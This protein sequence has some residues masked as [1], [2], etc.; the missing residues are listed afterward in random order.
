MSLKKL[1]IQRDGWIS[2]VGKMMD[3]GAPPEV[4]PLGPGYGVLRTMLSRF[5]GQDMEGLLTGENINDPSNALL[6]DALSHT[7]FGLFKFSLECQDD[8]YFFKRFAPD[9][10]VPTEV[11]RHHENEEMIFGQASRSVARPLPLL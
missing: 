1:L 6:L 8:R 2:L 10:K 11:L 3:E 4:S 5:V 7:A 9:R